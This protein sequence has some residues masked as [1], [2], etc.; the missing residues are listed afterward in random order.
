MLLWAVGPPLG[1]NPLRYDVSSLK[2]VVS[3]GATLA[4]APLCCTNMGHR[5]LSTGIEFLSIRW[6]DRE[7]S[8]PAYRAFPTSCVNDATSPRCTRA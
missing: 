6:T 1:F 4:Y 2:D 8:Y 5:T 7:G 3:R